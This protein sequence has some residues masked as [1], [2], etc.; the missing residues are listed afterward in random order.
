MKNNFQNYHVQH[1]KLGQSTYLIFVNFGTPPHYLGLQKVHRLEKST[2]PLVVMVVTNISYDN[3]LYQSEVIC[4]DNPNYYVQ[5][6][7]PELLCKAL[8]IGTISLPDVR[9]L[10][11][12]FKKPSVKMVASISCLCKSA[13]PRL[14]FCQNLTQLKGRRLTYPSYC[15]V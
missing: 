14:R 13:D 5:N 2:Q 8:R 7:C 12:E 3:L 15:G 1:G 6:Y 11:I 9:R 4:K 10:P